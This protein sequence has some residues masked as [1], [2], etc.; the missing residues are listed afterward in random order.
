VTGFIGMNLIAA[1][2][3]PLIEKIIFFVIVF[4]PVA[5]LTFYTIV[6]SRRLSDF[7]D[8]LS[9]ERVSARDKFMALIDVWRKKKPVG[10]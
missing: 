1:H 7:L 9:D 5:F 4:V 6:K 2:E 8:V 10:D 3:I